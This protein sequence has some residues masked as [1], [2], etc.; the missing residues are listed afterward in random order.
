MFS[1]K[2]LFATAGCI[3]PGIN[4][5]STY[6]VLRVGFTSSM[7]DLV[8]E[9]GRCRRGSND[10]NP[11]TSETFVLLI[12]FFDFI[13]I[14]KRIHKFSDIDKEQNKDHVKINNAIINEE[15]F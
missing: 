1:P 7:L 9:M 5:E 10:D 14:V 13:C 3:G 6:L 15:S 11:A 8:Q 12:N 4:C 2:N